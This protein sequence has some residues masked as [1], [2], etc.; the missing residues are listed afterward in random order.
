[1]LRV[2]RLALLLLLPLGGCAWLLTVPVEVRSDGPRTLWDLQAVAPGGDPAPLG[3]WRGR[4]A[5]VVNTA[6]ECGFA[7]QLE[8]LERLQRRY[9]ARGLVVLGV[10]SDDFGG[11][12]PGS[13][14][15]IERACRGDHGVTFPL[16]GKCRV[17]AGPEQA[18]VFAWL[19]ARTGSLPGWNFG[20]YLVGRDG[21]ARAFYA[22]PVAPQ[23]PAL[24]AELEAAL[25]EPALIVEPAPPAAIDSTS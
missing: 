17:R 11:Q 5:L 22:T 24:L 9:A 21:R 19:S 14:E 1:M 20:K 18:P 16:F 10:P 7:D 4:V 23:D 2:S 6:S 13:P 12:E 8:G 3:S 15:E 25:A